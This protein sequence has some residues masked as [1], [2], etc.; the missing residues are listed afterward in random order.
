MRD[1]CF[2]MNRAKP[3]KYAVN[4]EKNIL[5]RSTITFSILFPALL[6]FG[7]GDSPAN[8]A[9]ACR[10]TFYSDGSPKTNCVYNK[11]S[12]QWSCTDYYINGRILSNYYCDSNSYF[13][14]GLKKAYD[15]YGDIA[16]IVNRKNELLHGTFTEY[17][18][19]GNIKR[20]GE[21]YN[22]FRVGT[23]HEY[24]ENGG[25]KSEQKF[26][27]S[28]NDSLYNWE[29]KH[30]DSLKVFSLTVIFGT[31]NN[32]EP[33]PEVKNCELINSGPQSFC[34]DEMYGYEGI[35][36]GTWRFFNQ[37]GALIKTETYK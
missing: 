8:Q 25:L 14:T 23:W 6:S 31:F 29:N 21:F 2:L 36:T 18:C 27:I 3:N 24:Y 16:Y 34:K 9:N 7:Q 22:S 17:F 5:R 26:K 37:K 32:L 4:V 10:Q 1:V 13:P 35:K 33:L 30:S 12:K 19:N 28:K 20:C 15:V 11:T